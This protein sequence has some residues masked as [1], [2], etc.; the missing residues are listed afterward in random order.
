MSGMVYGEAGCN[1]NV[2]LVIVETACNVH[3][4]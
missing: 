4:S 1:F 2:N 3:A